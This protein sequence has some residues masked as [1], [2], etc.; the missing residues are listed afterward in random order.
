MK[1]LETPRLVLRQFNRDD[2]GFI[3]ELVNDPDWLRFIGDRG[4]HNLDDARGYIERGPMAM[5]A[6]HG[7]SLYCVE[8]KA[9][10]TPI[11]MC[12]LL[13]RDT[14]E[15]V[16]IGF[17]F[18]PRFRSRGYAREAAQATLSYG[19]DVLRLR[20][21]IATTTP[22]NDASGVLLGKIGLRFERMFTVPG[23]SRE[24]RLYGLTLPEAQG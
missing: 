13:K 12:G 21:I 17:A 11:G 7:F 20:R 18:L 2:A 22:D 16:D 5:Y 10:A 23:E 9:D 8:L 3:L 19:A 6:R 1:V 24:V 14:L 4:V 15:D